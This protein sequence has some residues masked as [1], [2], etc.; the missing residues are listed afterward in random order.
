MFLSVVCI[1]GS[2]H[3]ICVKY[4]LQEE[5]SISP[6]A[7]LLLIDLTFV[8]KCRGKNKSKPSHSV[9]LCD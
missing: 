1:N 7:R 8:Y 4:I 3:F 6:P 9:L 2:A 5:S